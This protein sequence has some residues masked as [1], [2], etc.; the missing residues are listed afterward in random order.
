MG[1]SRFHLLFYAF[2]NLPSAIGLDLEWPFSREGDKEIEGKVSLVQLCD[3]KTILLIH[4]SKMKSVY[5][6]CLSTS[7][8]GVLIFCK[9]FP[10]KVKVSAIFA[11]SSGDSERS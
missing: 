5:T 3:V 8:S 11:A 6:V 10:Q 4:V 7:V 1:K 2:T 9:G